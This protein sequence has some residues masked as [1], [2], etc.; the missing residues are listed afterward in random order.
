MIK[1]TRYI[2]QNILLYCFMVIACIIT[3]STQV[4]IPIYL[5][6]I[7]A[8]VLELDRHIV[9]NGCVII[10]LLAFVRL[11]CEYIWG[12]FNYYLSN[13]LLIS[14]ENDYVQRYLKKEYASISGN[15]FVY[16]SQRINN[17]IVIIMDYYIEKMPL[18]VCHFAKLAIIIT[19]LFIRDINIGLLSLSCMLLVIAVFVLSRKR[20][21]MLNKK[22]SESESV[23]F[24]YVGERLSRV[25]EIKLGAKY[26][27]ISN[28][29]QTIGNKFAKNAVKYLDFDNL[30]NI[31]GSFLITAF[32]AI[33]IIIAR[34][35]Y[36]SCPDFALAEMIV[37][38]IF[39]FQQIIADVNYLLGYSGIRQKYSVSKS[40]LNDILSVPVD[41][42]GTEELDNISIISG[43]NLHFDYEDKRI[44]KNLNFEFERGKIYGIVGRNGSGK[45]TLLLMLLGI[46]K[47]KSGVI[48]WNKINIRDINRTKLIREKIAV[49]SQEPVLLGKTIG[50][51]IFE[52]NE[53]RN[54]PDNYLELIG[55]INEKE[56]GFD[57]AVYI[58]GSNM[59]GGEKQRIAIIN[60]LLKKPDVL[61]LDEPTSALDIK[62]AEL[63]SKILLSEKNNRVTVI[64]SHDEEFLKIC[65]NMIDLSLK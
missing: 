47:P 34:I 17:D 2:K 4:I 23:F 58:N 63:L 53:S 65:D 18:L 12:H 7:G 49:T 44:I 37:L 27:E 51:C 61:I 33:Y 64:I 21:F 19:I 16:L 42:D 24:A 48:R 40:R 50:D 57:T 20:M 30:V 35:Q 22:T 5:S 3:M 39:Y 8:G 56:K 60:S 6:N 62:S 15:N 28:D 9:K 11:A 13:K 59:S 10:I 31:L 41:L 54:L 45:S 29:F 32:L 55:F 38:S 46:L 43:E 25:R 1:Y 36:D 14:A 26:Q 52:R